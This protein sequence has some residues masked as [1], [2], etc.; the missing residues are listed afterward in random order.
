MNINRPR[1]NTN[2]KAISQTF[3]NN[4]VNIK[5]L[6][7]RWTNTKNDYIL[8][9]LQNIS[10]IL[11]IHLKMETKWTYSLEKTIQYN[12][13]RK[14]KQAYSTKDT[15]FIVKNLPRKKVPGPNGPVTSGLMNFFKNS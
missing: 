8:G 3:Q 15:E 5:K 13:R 6:N 12:I 4:H 9:K 7:K 14:T 10:N 1:Q 2:V 11:P